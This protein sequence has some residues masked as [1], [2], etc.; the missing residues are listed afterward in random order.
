MPDDAETDRSF[1]HET[2]EAALL[3]RRDFNLGDVTNA[4]RVAARLRDHNR[5]EFLGCLQISLRQH[6][7][8]AQTAL[9]T[10]RRNLHIL[11]AQ[12]ALNIGGRQTKSCEL[13]RLDKDAHRGL[14]LPEN[15]QISR[16]WQHQK[17]RLDQ[18]VHGVREL[19]LRMCVR[20]EREPHYR[21]RISLHF[22]YHRLVGGVW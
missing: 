18:P 3:R 22:C 13:G 8:F 21:E 10:A 5:A 16:T 12:C 1:A 14:A 9:D 7:K 17:T 19:Q 2:L 6:V 15:A 20:G 11:C 4:N